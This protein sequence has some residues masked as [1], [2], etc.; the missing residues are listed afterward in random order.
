M[1]GKA[2]M[3]L[4]AAGVKLFEGLCGI[5]SRGITESKFSEYWKKGQVHAGFKQ[6][7]FSE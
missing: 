2:V 5:Y 4:D 6:G 7:E 3:E 1:D